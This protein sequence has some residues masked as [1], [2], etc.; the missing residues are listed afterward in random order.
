MNGH[1]P[2]PHLNG[3]Q[4]AV[5]DSQGAPSTFAPEAAPAIHEAA[6]A[7]YGAG[8]NAVFGRIAQEWEMIKKICKQSSH[9]IAALLA[10]AQPIAATE[11]DPITI[12]IGVEHDFHLG[13]LSQ[14]ANRQRV[15]WS[16]QQGVDVLCQVKFVPQSE[17]GNYAALMPP[18]PA[19][20]APN[21]P[22]G[23]PPT[24][25]DFTPAGP[26]ARPPADAF[27]APPADVAHA[28]SHPATPASAPLTPDQRAPATP[29]PQQDALVQALQRDY[30]ATIANVR[31]R[32]D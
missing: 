25:P 23:S 31:P 6:A 4:P 15:V 22:P 26:P 18:A 20:T 17:S 13:K 30:R 29:Q 16:I 5:P 9:S 8:V 3:H 27:P 21:L 10:D 19:P 28:P 1:Q 7:N 11:G 24:A 12:I 14:P 32:H 2:A